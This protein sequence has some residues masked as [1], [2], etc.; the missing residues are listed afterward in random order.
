MRYLITDTEYTTWPGALESGW[1]PAG[2]HREIFQMGVVLTDGS[3]NVVDTF[4]TLVQPK[5]NPI[6]SDLSRNLTGILQ[7]DIDKCGIN[8]PQAL[9]MFVKMAKR[10]DAIMQ[11]SV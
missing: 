9:A 11:L 5:I 6:L 1:S 7:V 10:A 8:F 3:F 4:S 2:Q